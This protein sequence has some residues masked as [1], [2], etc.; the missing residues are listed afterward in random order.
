MDRDLFMRFRG[1]GIG[2]R[3][4]RDSNDTFDLFNEK[5][6]PESRDTEDEN[7]GNQAAGV[8]D[9]EA[10][11]QE[12]NVQPDEALDPEE[13]DGEMALLRGMEVEMMDSGDDESDEQS[14]SNS[15]SDDGEWD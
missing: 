1:E 7:D 6:I 12:P 5:A 8:N 10:E 3:D 15:S 13:L 14:S 11:R 2:H 4:L 9:E